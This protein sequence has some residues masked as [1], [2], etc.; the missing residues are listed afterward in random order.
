M[1]II[2]WNGRELNLF[3]SNTCKCVSYWK[4]MRNPLNDGFPIV[5][6]QVKL[7]IKIFKA[8]VICKNNAN[9][10]KEYGTIF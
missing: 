10:R 1:E 9:E 6:Y 5:L 2:I 7:K 8:S 3:S 4:P